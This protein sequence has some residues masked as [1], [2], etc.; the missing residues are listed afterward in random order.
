MHIVATGKD[1]TTRI[2]QNQRT[3]PAANHNALIELPDYEAYMGML[4]ESLGR[5]RIHNRFV[6]VMLIGLD[7]FRDANDVYGHDDGSRV[8]QA[9]AKRI[10]DA[11][12]DVDVVACLDDNTFKIGRAHV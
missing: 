8:L 3:T 10:R 1:V 4:K 9:Y 12:R 7:S 6:A 5:A 2:H 11:V